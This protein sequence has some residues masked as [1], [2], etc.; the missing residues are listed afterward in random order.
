MANVFEFFDYRKFL[1]A[2]YEER[3]RTN[4]H[5]SHRYIARKVGCDSGYFA[6][7]IQEQRHISLAMAEGFA[8]CFG[9]GA[10][11]AEYFKCL[12]QFEKA[13]TQADKK[14]IFDRLISF[15]NSQAKVLSR[16]QYEV[17]DKWY[18]LAVREALD[19]FPFK[20]DCEELGRRIDP[21]LTAAQVRKSLA[22]LERVGLIA[23]RGRG[24]ER[25]EPIWRTEKAV[26]SVC[27][28]AFQQAMLDLARQA[29]DRAPK[30]H[31]DLSTLTLSIS[32]EDYLAMV[33][34][35]EALRSRFL[36]RARASRNSDRVYQCSILLFPLT[37]IES[38]EAAP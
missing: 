3:K 20:G 28:E 9:L 17:F 25:T 11:E 24:Y 37:R 19:C 2:A 33:R 34:E 23:R 21:P 36:E 38:D 6:K 35:L 14:Q 12:I 27:V 16:T 30:A 15:Q 1:R 29:Y 31:R 13:R 32:R 26:A 4:P 8:A 5:F 18:Y 7:I 10:R 22:V